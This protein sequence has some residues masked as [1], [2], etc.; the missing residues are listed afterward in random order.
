MRQQGDKRPVV[1][2]ACNR[3]TYDLDVGDVDRTRLEATAEFRYEEFDLPT[4]WDEPP[5][6]DADTNA[7]FNSF[8]SGLSIL[9][10]V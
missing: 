10:L 1:G 3:A 4:S 8:V 6:A 5:V 2:I 9:S 7:R